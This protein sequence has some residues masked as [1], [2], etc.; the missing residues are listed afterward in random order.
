MSGVSH[1]YLNSS[2]LS[3]EEPIYPNECGI[4]LEDIMPDIFED[5]HYHHHASIEMNYLHQGEMTYSFSGDDVT[6]KGGCFTLFWGANPHR[7]LSLNG[8][9]QIT[10]VYISLSQLLQWNLPSSFISALLSGSVICARERDPIDVQLVNRWVK[11]KTLE[12][13]W[14]RLH[15]LEVEARLLRLSNEG[16]STILRREKQD[17]S[18]L[19]GGKAILHFEAMLRFMSEHFSSPIGLQEVADYTGVSKGYAMSLFKKLLGKTIKEHL[20]DLRMYHAK[21][22]LAESDTKIVAIA[23]DSGF[24]SLSAFYDVFQK[25]ESISP[26]AF[27]KRNITEEKLHSSQDGWS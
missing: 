24:G 15:A 20:T 17:A 27:R 5:S 8:A 26:A 14:H 25:Y 19:V 4:V 18:S 1:G 11:E 22:L 12:G 13:N 21:M 2:T 10:N 6:I 7:V 23:L 9:S 16:W 3:I